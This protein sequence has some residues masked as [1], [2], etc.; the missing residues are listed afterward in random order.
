MNASDTL[1]VNTVVLKVMVTDTMIKRKLQSFKNSENREVLNQRV[2][3][4]L[5]HST[6]FHK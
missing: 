1:F 2:Q 5:Q 6:D 3:Q 4:F